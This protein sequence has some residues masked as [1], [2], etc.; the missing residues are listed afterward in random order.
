MY[1]EDTEKLRVIRSAISQALADAH[2]KDNTLDVDDLVIALLQCA[3]TAVMKMQ[4][5][6]STNFKWALDNF[7]LA[8][9]TSAPEGVEIELIEAAAVEDAH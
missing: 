1:E 3:G 5:E 9:Q 8:C 6:A 4:G 7:V 2:K